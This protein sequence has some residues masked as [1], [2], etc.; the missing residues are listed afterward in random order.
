MAYNFSKIGKTVIIKEGDT[1]IA[2]IGMPVNVF[3][4][5]SGE[6][7]QIEIRVNPVSAPIFSCLL[8]EIGTIN[9][10]GLTNPPLGDVVE[11]L[12]LE[13]FSDDNVPS[14]SKSIYKL[15]RDAQGDIIDPQAKI[16][17]V[18][19]GLDN[20]TGSS[21][22]VSLFKSGT[23]DVLFCASIQSV[24]YNEVDAIIVQTDA[25]TIEL[26]PQNVSSYND[27]SNAPISNP[28]LN[29]LMSGFTSLIGFSVL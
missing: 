23:H 2:S 26:A 28:T 8:S 18:K 24:R 21:K 7:Q 1:T 4:T 10:D 29:D 19:T 11:K 20:T 12:A 5:G 3:G 25:G 22:V 17:E 16:Y 13:V 6:N 15:E 27:N 9:D 14:Q